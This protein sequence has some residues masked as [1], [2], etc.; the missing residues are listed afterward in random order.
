MSVEGLSKP[1]LTSGR[2][3]WVQNDLPIFRSY[4]FGISSL[5]LSLINALYIEVSTFASAC[6]KGTISLC[7]SFIH[8]LGPVP[9]PPNINTLIYARNYL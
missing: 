1:Q 3:L 8:P 7:T 4:Y 6:R 5:L 2:I 9:T